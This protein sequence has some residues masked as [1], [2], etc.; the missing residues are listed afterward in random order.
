MHV[1]IAGT[2]DFEC[3]GTYPLG[4]EEVNN[5]RCAPTVAEQAAID[6]VAL[7][8]SDP[9]YGTHGAP[10]GTPADLLKV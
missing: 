5:I 2:A 1:A 4:F 9:L 10:W 7:F 8:E 6:A 3:A